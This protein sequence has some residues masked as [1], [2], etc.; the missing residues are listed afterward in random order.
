MKWLHLGKQGKSLDAVILVILK[1]NFLCKSKQR[2]HLFVYCR[3]KM[4]E[5]LF[6]CK[7]LLFLTRRLCKH[8]PESEYF[9]YRSFSYIEK[10]GDS[11]LIDQSVYTR[12]EIPHPC[13]LGDYFV[14]IIPCDCG[15]IFKSHTI[16]G[17]FCKICVVMKI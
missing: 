1:F 13:M 8:I 2:M 5:K 16:K 12:S 14:R 4:L 11:C 10:T 9:M 7:P 17:M 15:L 3:Q 6:S